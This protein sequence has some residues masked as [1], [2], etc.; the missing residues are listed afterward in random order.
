MQARVVGR[1]LVACAA[2]LVGVNAASDAT[3]RTVRGARLYV[4]TFGDG[5]PILFLHGGLSSFDG[6]FAQ[7]RDF[8]AAFRRVIG[9]DQRGHGHSP[10]TDAA[11]SYRDM[12]EDSAALIEQLAVAP[13]DVVG[14]SDGGNV[15]LLLASRHPQLVRRVVVSGANLRAGQPAAEL[16]RRAALSPQEIVQRLASFRA[17]YVRVSPD[18]ADHWPIFAAKSWRLWLTPVIIER[19]ELAAI[20]APVLVIAGEHDLAPLAETQEIQRHLKHGALMILPATGHSTFQDRPDVI[21]PAI[22]AFLEEP[23]REKGTP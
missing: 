4:Q 6:S 7:Q 13:V 1:V 19:A 23:E 10:D 17:D 20:E 9:V 15:A 3:L 21:N 5:A 14:H 18:G 8:F 11:F 2:L 12:A 22:R 16:K